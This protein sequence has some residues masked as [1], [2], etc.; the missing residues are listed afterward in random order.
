MDAAVL[1]VF[2][3][4]WEDEVARFAAKPQNFV[5]PLVRPPQERPNRVEKT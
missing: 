3:R 4:Q 1:L 5:R 2:F